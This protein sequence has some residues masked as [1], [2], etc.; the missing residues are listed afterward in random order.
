MGGNLPAVVAYLTLVG[1]VLPLCVDTFAVAAALGVAGLPARD[2]LRVSL[3]MTAF[4]AG[5]PLVGLAIG[6][7]AGA[8]IGRFAG[9]AA[10]LLIA[11]LGVFMLRSDADDEEESIVLLARARGLAVL[12]LGLTISL[13]ELAIGFSL[14]LL[15]LP[16]VP[17]IVLIA[18]QGFIA[19]QA[20]L[21]LGSRVT[22]VAR[23]RSAKAAGAILILLA[24][25]LGALQLIR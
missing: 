23:E 14:G 10:I 2:R 12:G 25:V 13:D 16:L 22:E 15:R 20:G 17:A 7:V 8:L 18:A 19:S 5:M 24:V 21:R 3:V 6:Q 11:G 9:Y 1:L 4:E